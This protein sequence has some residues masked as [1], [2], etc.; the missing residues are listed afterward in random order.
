M[1]RFNINLFR[2]N[3]ILFSF[4]VA[5][6]MLSM[7]IEDEMATLWGLKYIYYSAALF[8][9]NL[10]I[11]INYGNKI[12]FKGLTKVILLWTV[13]VTMCVLLNANDVI[14]N[15]LKI[16]L[17]T[18]TYYAAYCIGKLDVEIIKK[19]KKT[20]FI[21]FCVG[22][23]YFI[24]SKLYQY[25]IAE[26]GL[27]SRSNTIFCMVTVLP[28][29]LFYENKRFVVCIIIITLI[30]GI[31]SNKRS[32]VIMMSLIAFPVIQTI[33]QDFGRK[34][35]KY[36]LFI[37]ILFGLIF[38]ALYVESSQMSGDILTRFNDIDETGGSGRQDIWDN[39]WNSYKSSDLISQIF[40]HGHEAVRK[41]EIA[42]TAHND[43]L[44]VLFDYGI[45]GLCFYVILHLSLYKK[46]FQLYKSNH[47]YF[48][49]YFTML[50]IFIVMSCVSILMMQMKYLI[51][52][53]V[54][55]GTMEATTTNND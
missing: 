29:L 40:G 49:Y 14:V 12:V 39:V 47:P 50:I 46:C 23:F 18:S 31:F 11:V 44:D 24:L 43:F 51:Y 2:F 8:I 27:L 21:V 9:V 53:A 54:F 36:I 38:I 25:Q 19:L 5:S 55:W 30:A 48:P 37:I 17:W 13:Y 4:A 22:A 26:Y 33:L 6:S 45:I 42:T 16:N 20:F 34:S 35:S 52:M 7:V 28:W 41:Y 15:V 3:I 32:V 1:R 10:Y